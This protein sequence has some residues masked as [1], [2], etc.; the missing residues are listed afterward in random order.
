MIDVVLIM[1]ICVL[2]DWHIKVQPLIIH[3]RW[4]NKVYSCV[5]L[6]QP[7]EFECFSRDFVIGSEGKCYLQE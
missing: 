3:N 4:Y 5:I 7:S 6:L 2:A 1:P